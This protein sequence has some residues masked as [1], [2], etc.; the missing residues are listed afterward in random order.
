MSLYVTGGVPSFVPVNFP[1]PD[2]LGN[3]TGSKGRATPVG[4]KNPDN[5][6]P[7]HG[8]SSEPINTT[9]HYP[10]ANTKQKKRP[11]YSKIARI[12]AKSPVSNHPTR[13]SLLSW[14]FAPDVPDPVTFTTTSSSTITSNSNNAPTWSHARMPQYR[15]SLV[16]TSGWGRG[17]GLGNKASSGVRILNFVVCGSRQLW[18]PG[19]G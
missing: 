3:L 18:Q 2:V 15:N 10:P 11:H 12:Q 7:L 5:T 9:M 6:A 14:K 17:R 19:G 8:L 1:I 16:S 13:L 4:C